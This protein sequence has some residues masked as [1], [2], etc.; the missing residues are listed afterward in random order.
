VSGYVVFV[1]YYP[2]GGERL[3]DRRLHPDAATAGAV[4]NE[5]NASGELNGVAIYR[6]ATAD[7]IAE[8]QPV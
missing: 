2:S 7:D 4:A 6:K 8:T 3:Y 1:R 5:L